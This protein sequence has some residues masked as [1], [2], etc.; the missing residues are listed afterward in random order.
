M[1][2]RPAT[3]AQT[4]KRRGALMFD[5]LPPGVH[6]E[7][8]EPDEPEPPADPDRHYEARIEQKEDH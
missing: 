6:P 5:N 2:D 3:A 1:A 4:S 8:C 7:D